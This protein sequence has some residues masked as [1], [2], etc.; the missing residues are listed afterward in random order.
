M[1]NKLNLLPFAHLSEQQITEI[2]KLEK[3]LGGEDHP[4]Y[5]MA[6]KPPEIKG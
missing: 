5:L 4:V 6:L 1:F 2:K 3:T